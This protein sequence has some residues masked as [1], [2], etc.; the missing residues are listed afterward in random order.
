MSS[1]QVVYNSRHNRLE[2]STLVRVKLSL[3]YRRQRRLAGEIDLLNGRTVAYGPIKDVLKYAR[4][5]K[6]PLEIR[7]AKAK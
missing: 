2:A 6:C 5:Y 4:V 1:L 7:K 3:H